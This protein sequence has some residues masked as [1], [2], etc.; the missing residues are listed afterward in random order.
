MD[1]ANSNNSEEKHADDDDD[2]DGTAAKAK[3]TKEAMLKEIEDVLDIFGDAYMNKHLVYGI[4]ELCIVRLFPEV[5]ETGVR[6]L[7]EGRLGGDI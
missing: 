1:V 2:D 7:M 3:K 6:D 4:L 5:G